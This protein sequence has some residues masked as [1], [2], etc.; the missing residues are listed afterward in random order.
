MMVT[1]L[2]HGP[3]LSQNDRSVQTDATTAARK[4]SQTFGDFVTS[5]LTT[6]P[7]KVIIYL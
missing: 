3:G 4:F 7:K 2:A 6:D 5:C 1:K